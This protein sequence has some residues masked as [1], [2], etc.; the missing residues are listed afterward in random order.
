ME[1]NVSTWSSM[2]FGR[3]QATPWLSEVFHKQS[4]H[5]RHSKILTAQV[6]RPSAVWPFLTAC[7]QCPFP[8]HADGAS[9]PAVSP[10]G[11]LYSHPRD[12][13]HARIVYRARIACRQGPMVFSLCPV[14]WSTLYCIAMA[15]LKAK[16]TP[17]LP[18]T[19]SLQVSSWLPMEFGSIS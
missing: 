5:E 4:F 13:C 17:N 18:A 15:T 19:S 1:V 10:N 16:Q 14:M 7:A 6:R 8:K 12:S 9:V 11:M 3:E 2:I